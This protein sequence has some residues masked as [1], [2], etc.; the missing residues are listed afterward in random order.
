MVTEERAES[1]DAAGT[2]ARFFLVDPLDGT[3]EFIGRNGEFTVNIALIEDGVPT[4]GVVYAPAVDR[5]FYTRARDH[6]VEEPAPHDPAACRPLSVS[7]ADNTALRVVASRSHRDSATDDYIGRYRVTEFHSAGS[8]L[9]FCLIAPEKLIFIPAS[10]APW[11]GT[12]PRDTRFCRRPAAR[13]T[14]SM[15]VPCTM[16]NPDWTTRISSPIRPASP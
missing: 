9:K 14:G 6:A 12:R 7:S 5:L 1:H 15:A 4:L 13:W 11:N 10:A 2:A 3:R 16:A 8:S